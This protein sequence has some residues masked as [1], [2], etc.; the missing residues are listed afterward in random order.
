M[1]KANKHREG[2]GEESAAYEMF[3]EWASHTNIKIQQADWM[4][5]IQNILSSSPSSPPGR[6]QGDRLVGENLPKC[7]SLRILESSRG[8][9]APPSVHLPVKV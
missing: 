4:C 6:T 8:H 2:R 3:S 5:R 9:P 7:G 1:N